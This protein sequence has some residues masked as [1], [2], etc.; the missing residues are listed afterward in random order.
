M[1]AAFLHNKASPT[2]GETRGYTRT[3]IE[4]AFRQERRGQL[5][6]EDR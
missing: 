3:Q 1:G 5:S 6:G 4:D 2:P